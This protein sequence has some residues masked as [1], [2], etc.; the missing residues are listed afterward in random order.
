MSVTRCVL[1]F[2]NRLGT[3][4]RTADDYKRLLADTPEACPYADCSPGGCRAHCREFA[5]G[6][7]VKQHA[8]LR[9]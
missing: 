5:T 1:P 9:K 6:E 2:G 4:P 8:E 7:W 3:T